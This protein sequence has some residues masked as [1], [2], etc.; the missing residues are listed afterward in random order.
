MNMETNRIEYK[1]TLT[2]KLE[3]EVVAFLNYHEGGNIH[4]GI[5]DNGNAV[6]VEGID[7]TQLKIIDR[8]KNNI[9]PSTLGLFD[10]VA[11]DVSGKNTINIIISSGSE[12][13]YVR[14][15]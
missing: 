2:D 4:I 12:K 3:R 5:D 10:V 8:I 14:I 9:L 15:P 7:S 6:G 13:P 11:E 1:S